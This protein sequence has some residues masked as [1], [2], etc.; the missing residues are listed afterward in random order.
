MQN[1]T[2]LR[3][4]LTRIPVSPCYSFHMNKNDDGLFRNTLA[5]NGIAD[6]YASRRPKRRRKLIGW[7]IVLVT[8][9]GL[10]L[11]DL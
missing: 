3:D 10:T 11:I 1:G 7:T 2:H 6:G 4:V 8:L 5:T 9:G